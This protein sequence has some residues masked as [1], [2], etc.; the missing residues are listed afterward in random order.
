MIQLTRSDPGRNMHRFCAVEC[1]RER[2]KPHLCD[3]TGKWTARPRAAAVC[4]APDTFTGLNVIVS[5]SSPWP[6]L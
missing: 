2:I 3:A 1:V 4:V 6:P 5:R